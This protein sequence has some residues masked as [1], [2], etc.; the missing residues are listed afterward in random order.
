MNSTN[1]ISYIHYNGD[2]YVFS[3][4]LKG[5]KGK[6]YHEKMFE[7]EE[8]IYNEGKTYKYRIFEE[9]F[10]YVQKDGKGKVIKKE[11]AKRKVL[12][13]WKKINCRPGSAQA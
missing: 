7:D 10:Q 3:Q 1:N 4:I 12:I 13:Y 5:K 11:T 2:G 8:F 6:R 9:D